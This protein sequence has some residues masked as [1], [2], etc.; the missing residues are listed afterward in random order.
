MVHIHET[1]SK[2]KKFWRLY[3]SVSLGRGGGSVLL[4][5]AQRNLVSVRFSI[6]VLQL[7]FLYKRICNEVEV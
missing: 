5:V 6:Y 7:L 4:I 2:G 1:I 3:V